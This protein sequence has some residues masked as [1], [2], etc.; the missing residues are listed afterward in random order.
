MERYDGFFS[1]LEFL[2]CVVVQ[3]VLT[4]VVAP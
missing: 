1:K 3:G 2:S 4:A